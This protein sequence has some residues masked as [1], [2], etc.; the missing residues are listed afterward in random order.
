MTSAPETVSG[1]IPPECGFVQG[2]AHEVYHNTHGRASAHGLIQLLRSPAHYRASWGEGGKSEQTEAMRFGQI[3]HQAILEPS[4][5]LQSYRVMPEFGPMQ[6]SKNREKR[7]EW[8]KSLPPGAIVLTQEEVDQVTGMM[9]AVRGHSKAS[10]LLEE[11]I[12]EISGFWTD[13]QTGVKCRIRPDY[14]R[15][16]G[17]VIDYKTATDASYKSFQG[18]A[19]KF[20]YHVQA[21]FYRQ[22]VRA[23][24][25]KACDGFVFIVQEKTPPY[26]V[27]VYAADDAFLDLGRAHV[28][29][30]LRL[31]GE[32]QRQDV[33]PAYPEIIMN[34]SPPH[35]AFYQEE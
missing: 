25:R 16:D 15:T 21:A 2:L 8:L 29:K 13:P 27:M 19:L 20:G 5:F 14:L 3:V 30:A 34:L 1:F 23:I 32:C 7:D 17:V 31:F 22:G 24:S 6:S 35:W 26:A 18:A 12:P 11:G 9:N 33:W 28:K 4:R 10:R